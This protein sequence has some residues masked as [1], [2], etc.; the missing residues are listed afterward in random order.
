MKIP[1]FDIDVTYRE[2]KPEIDE[3]IQRVLN[4]GSYI[5]G[6][7]VEAFEREF[8]EYC[9]A[10]YC[11]GVS[12]GVDAL[13]L[14][15]RA[16][17]IGEGDEVLVPAH[18]FIA[19]W[20]A[21]SN[22]GAKPIPVDIDKNTYNINPKLIEQ[23][24]TSK[25]KAIIPVHLYGQSADM[26]SILSIAH[27]YGIRVIED[28]AQAQGAKY[29]KMK[30]GNIG[31]A[32]AFS[33]YPAKNLGAFG[34]AGAVTTNDMSLTENIKMLQ[35]YGS[36]EKYIHTKLGFNNRLDELQAAILRVKLK[37]LDDW[38]SRREIIANYYLNGL[39]G[40]DEYK[41][42]FV[43]EWADPVWH[44]FVI[45]THQRD[46]IQEY[47]Q[48]KNIQTAIHYPH[49]PYKNIFTNSSKVSPIANNFT[50]ECLSLPI[51]LSDINKE[52][53]SIVINALRRFIV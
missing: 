31:D 4:S 49:L 39:N 28:A 46:V 51:L 11:I 15:L 8:A 26:D 17:E 2:L 13:H 27:K 22:T 21:V 6:K 1:F 9:G 45:K 34:D 44:L 41:L 36:K 14:I 40:I 52:K 29:K 19:T 42:P 20:L 3:A 47:L 10:K 32:A 48:N 38:N 33:F 25:T 12:N 43:P 7:E 16:W 50:N 18:T 53:T 5:L 23:A 24:I 35:N 37:F 30:C